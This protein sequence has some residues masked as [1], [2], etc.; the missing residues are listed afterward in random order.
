[1]TPP[2]DDGRMLEYQFKH[3]PSGQEVVF[4]SQVTWGHLNTEPVEP[5]GSESDRLGRVVAPGR[6]LTVKT[7]TLSASMGDT[8]AV[9]G[10]NYQIRH[11]PFD[12]TGI[13]H[14]ELAD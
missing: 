9:G 5:F 7:G 6:M 11:P 2:F 14:Y 8:V 3:S 4:G 1:M 13:T 10:T 12:S